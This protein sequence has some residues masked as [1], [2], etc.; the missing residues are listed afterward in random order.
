ML[1][2]ELDW[3]LLE[4]FEQESPLDG[5]SGNVASDGRDAVVAGGCASL[6]AIGR[7]KLCFRCR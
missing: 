6:G 1:E 5:L 7:Y 2:L 3:R 4:P